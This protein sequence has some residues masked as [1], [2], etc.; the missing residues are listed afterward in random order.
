MYIYS[1]LAEIVCLFLELT[2]ASHMSQLHF[3]DLHPSLPP[4][5]EKYTCECSPQVSGYMVIRKFLETYNPL[6]VNQ[7]NHNYNDFNEKMIYFL[8][9]IKYWT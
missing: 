4:Q 1:T 8:E 5:R 7:N 6:F 9:R 2:L 3:T